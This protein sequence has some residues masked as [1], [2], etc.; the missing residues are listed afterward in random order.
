M[1]CAPND[2]IQLP[3]LRQSPR[4]HLLVIATLRSNGGSTPVHIRNMSARGAQIEAPD[5]PERDTSVVLKRGSLE[6][7]G[8]MAWSSRNR[9]GIAF[10]ALVHVPAWMARQS[11]R[12]QDLVDEVV[13]A[14][15]Y[16]T[17]AAAVC[18]DIEGELTGIGFVERELALLQADLSQ[19]GNLLI[20]DVIVA[21]TH[22]EIQLLD[23][24]IQRI[25]RIRRA[26]RLLGQAPD[27]SQ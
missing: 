27:V 24:A 23:V 20:A 8:R 21:A 18:R 3:N 12:Q 4:T 7:S 1:H 22:P 16:S 14:L 15:R 17:T 2:Q 13:S 11:N 5:L 26:I 25:E 19:L 9:A 10:D 6:I